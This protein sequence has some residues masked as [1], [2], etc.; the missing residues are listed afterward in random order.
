MPWPDEPL[1]RSHTSSSSHSSRHSGTTR[2][3][4][5]KKSNISNACLA[6]ST[7][8]CWAYA[9]F[10]EE[11]KSRSC[12]P[13]TTSLFAASHQAGFGPR[14]MKSLS[15]G[16]IKIRRHEV[17]IEDDTNGINI[18]GGQTQAQ[19]NSNFFIP[20][21][22]GAKRH[23]RGQPRCERFGRP[24]KKTRFTKYQ[25]K[26]SQPSSFLRD[27]SRLHVSQ[28]RSYGSLH[29]GQ[30]EQ[31]TLQVRLRDFSAPPTRIH[32]PVVWHSRCPES[33]SEVVKS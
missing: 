6:A 15:I 4:V 2:T 11:H 17:R 20:G 27:W 30:C 24:S 32:T 7:D 19:A 21:R 8:S 33:Q 3:G 1:D 9:T 18:R 22:R 10:L 23:Q 25:A 28:K 29:M 14:W 12:C 26:P 13:T 5:H 31:K 16:D